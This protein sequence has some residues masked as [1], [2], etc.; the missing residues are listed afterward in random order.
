MRESYQLGAPWT[1]GAENGRLEVASSTT[2]ALHNKA[3]KDRRINA[4]IFIHLSFEH[5]ASRATS[6]V[7]DV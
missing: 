5:H 4:S 3:P 2:L 7:V 1:N 6:D